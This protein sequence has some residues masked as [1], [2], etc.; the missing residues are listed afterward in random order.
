VVLEG[1]AKVQTSREMKVELVDCTGTE[2]EVSETSGIDRESTLL[3]TGAGL[4]V[5]EIEIYKTD[6]SKR[7][8]FQT[9]NECVVTLRVTV[10]D[11]W[12]STCRPSCRM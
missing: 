4:H 6:A 3:D 2:K 11:G 7:R 9:R 12:A 1:E 5:C 8:A 10:G